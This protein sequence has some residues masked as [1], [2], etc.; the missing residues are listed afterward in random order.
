MTR[1][2]WVGL[3]ALL[4]VALCGLVGVVWS[5]LRETL[6]DLRG[7]VRAAASH[8][9]AVDLRLTAHESADKVKGP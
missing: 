1:R 4:Y 7:D 5:D 3:C 9:D 6:R 2:E 8:V